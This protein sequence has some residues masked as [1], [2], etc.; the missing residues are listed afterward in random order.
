VIGLRHD[1]DGKGGRLRRSGGDAV[2]LVVQYLK[3]ETLEPLQGVG[4]FLVLGLA[5]A[6]LAGTGVVLL[7]V[8]VLRLLQTRTGL[9]GNLSWIPYLIVAGA[10][11]LV[12]ALLLW[13]ISKGAAARRR[14]VTEGEGH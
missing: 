8:G 6:V 5:G 7:L 9:T 1:D 14:P 3:Q 11:V 12:I 10:A 13:R 4:K 2:D